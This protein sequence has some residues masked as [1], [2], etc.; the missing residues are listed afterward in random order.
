MEKVS[1]LS[2]VQNFSDMM[3]FIFFLNAMVIFSSG[4]DAQ[5]DNTPVIFTNSQDIDPYRYRDVKGSPY[6]FENL[7]IGDIVSTNIDVYQDMPLNLNGYTKN[8][9]VRRGNKMVELDPRW[10]LR[11]EIHPEL[12]PGLD[13]AF[14]KEKLVFQRG[15]HPKLENVFALIIFAGARTIFLKTFHADLSKKKVEDVGKTLEFQRFFG[16]FTYYIIA[17][18]ELITVSTRKKTFLKALGSKKELETFAH[19]N[20][21]DF[22][23]EKDLIKLVAFYDKNL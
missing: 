16:K 2:V 1:I 4:L 20:N 21:I 8:F 23:S 18:G 14:G 3:R 6:L 17:D 10:Y 11:V 15:I 13:P 22:D 9:E 12:N 5:P 19:D 7:V